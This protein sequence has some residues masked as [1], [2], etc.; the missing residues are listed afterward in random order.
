MTEPSLT[1]V[2]NFCGKS[3]KEVKKLIS[4]PNCYICDECIGACNDIIAE[5]VE[6][7]DQEA[8]AAPQD[9]PD[10]QELFQELHAAV[11]GQND[12]KRS[13]VAALR[14]R[15]FARALDPVPRAPRI[16]WVGPGGVGKSTLG[17]A[18]CDAAP[19]PTYSFD[20]GRLSEA[21]Y[22]GDDVEH[23][24]QGLL[25]IAEG[26][27]P[28]TERGFV[29]L[30]GVE[31]LSLSMPRTVVHRDISGASVQRELLRL[32]EGKTMDVPPRGARHPQ[33][34]NISIDTNSIVIVA[35]VRLE[36]ITAPPGA[37]ERELRD[38]LVQA[39][40]LAAF[41]SRFDRV[42]FFRPL[43]PSELATVAERAFEHAKNEANAVGT[44]LD[45]RPDALDTLVSAAVASGEEG[46]GVAR[47]TQR[48]LEEVYV[49]ERPATTFTVDA[50]AVRAL[51]S[52]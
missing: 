13:L 45:L 5:E 9:P 38:L 33:Q 42:V 47:F 26:S 16:L 34:Q 21:G 39:G 1:L 30:D 17:L 46:F 10:P 11:V 36:G 27:I 25:A 20:V 7:E 35:A 51:L 3:Q 15:H 4:G 18:A 44:T 28:A 43:G 19:Y 29:F 24:I 49:A 6:K 12:A 52:R 50:A 14:R 22:V 40:L 23:I 8:D 48:L 31:K 32:L 41:V 2:C 37:T